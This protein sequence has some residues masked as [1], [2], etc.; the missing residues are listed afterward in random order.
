MAE[1]CLI[2]KIRPENE[3]RPSLETM[4]MLLLREKDVFTLGELDVARSGES[5]EMQGAYHL[6]SLTTLA[7]KQYLAG[8][9]EV[10]VEQ[11]KKRVQSW[12]DSAVNNSPYSVSAKRNLIRILGQIKHQDLKERAQIL[13]GL[14]QNNTPQIKLSDA[15]LEKPEMKTLA[16]AAPS[17]Q[18]IAIASNPKD[19]TGVNARENLLSDQTIFGSELETWNK[20]E[21]R[22]GRF[23]SIKKAIEALRSYVKGETNDTEL[24]LRMR[25]WEKNECF[26]DAFSQA[27]LLSLVIQLRTNAP[28]LRDEDA[29]F[30][31]RVSKAASLL[32]AAT[33]ERA[34]AKESAEVKAPAP[35]VKQNEVKKAPVVDDSLSNASLLENQLAAF[36]Q[37]QFRGHYSLGKFLNELRSYVGREGASYNS[38]KARLEAWV[39]SETYTSEISK[40]AR[41]RMLTVLSV[42]KNSEQD[43]S[44]KGRLGTVLSLVEK[45]PEIEV[46]APAAEEKPLEAEASNVVPLRGSYEGRKTRVEAYEF[47]PPNQLEFVRASTDI[48]SQ[49]LS[50]ALNTHGEFMEA[51]KLS[52]YFKA[53]VR[54]SANHRGEVEKVVFTSVE[55]E[56]YGKNSKAIPLARVGSFMKLL[57]GD[58]RQHMSFPRGPGENSTQF[59][60]SLSPPDAPQ[61][62]IDRNVM[63]DFSEQKPPVE[64]QAPAQPVMAP[65]GKN[66]DEV[67]SAYAFDLSQMPAPKTAELAPSQLPDILRSHA[68]QG[69]MLYAEEMKG[70]YLVKSLPTLEFD[71]NGFLS[72]VYFNEVSAEQGITSGAQAQ[73]AFMLIAS[74]WRNV[75]YK[76]NAKVVL[77]KKPSVFEGNW[78]IH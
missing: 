44:V 36:E 58:Y 5:V 14:I 3:V 50:I 70:H 30:Q 64:Q 34:E 60:I 52:F 38:L 7:F 41:S 13:L 54:I 39:K 11:L 40:T 67:K 23:Y 55:A 25:M 73:K 28:L 20:S 10:S 68:K 9:C 48:N 56:A 46:P 2:G 72:K 37:D 62:Q 43:K 69:S 6:I 49:R 45:S 76:P 16:D 4:V 75:R 1:L 24:K 18:R 12:N 51:Q 53:T 26:Q 63:I 33:S 61:H 66:P 27:V 17:R 15:P 42:W 22:N 32:P 29:A 21:V 77:G 35:E 8:S 65:Q 47:S 19:Y 74:E 59:K 71:A 78:S 31:E 57:A